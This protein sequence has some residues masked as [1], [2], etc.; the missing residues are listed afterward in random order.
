[1]K[2]ACPSAPMMLTLTAVMSRL[3]IRAKPTDGEPRAAIGPARVPEALERLGIGEVGA[4][5]R[6][7]RENT[8]GDQS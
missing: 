2:V 7:L 1:M 3:G 4:Q 6:R 5:Y 8:V